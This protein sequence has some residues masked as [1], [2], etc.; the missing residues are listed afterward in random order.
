LHV[1][2][3]REYQ[4]PPLSFGGAV[5]DA[6]RLSSFSAVR[7]FIDRAVEARFDF[8]VTNENAPAVAAICARLDGHPLSIELA[9]ARVK[10]LSPQALLARLDSALSV[11]ASTGGDRP[12]RQQTLAATITWS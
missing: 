10:I 9:A 12:D 5:G 2:G 4:L 8:T 11:L 3:E 6:D 1:R 7:L